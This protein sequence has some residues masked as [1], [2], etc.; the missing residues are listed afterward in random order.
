MKKESFFYL[1]FILT[2]LSV[3]I[4]VM[5]F[6]EIDLNVS[7]V[8]IHHFWFGVILIFLVFL[9]PKQ[10]IYLKMLFL[11]LGGGLILDELVFI[12]LG[13]GNDKEY[14]ALPSLIGTVIFT[15]IVYPFRK[16]IIN[17]FLRREE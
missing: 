1:L 13:A 2:I 4:L 5:V 8:I 3:R 7:G 12:L 15:M 17:L 16:K 10:K 9:I 11:G 14:W 6:P